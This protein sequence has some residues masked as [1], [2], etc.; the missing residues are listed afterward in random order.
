[1]LVLPECACITR[2]RNSRKKASQGPEQAFNDSDALRAGRVSS[3]L[4]LSRAQG[5]EAERSWDKRGAGG[6]ARGA[7]LRAVCS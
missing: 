2:H 6:R 3:A 4:W 1:M 7:G 5:G